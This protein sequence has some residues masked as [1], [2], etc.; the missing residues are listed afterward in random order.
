[1]II[2]FVSAT[3]WGGGGRGLLTCR[4]TPPCS[5]CE[6]GRRYQDLRPPLQH[7][8]CCTSLYQP[9]PDHHGLS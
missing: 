1:M 9:A 4:E 8:R 2:T 5:G 6:G 7:P 3:N